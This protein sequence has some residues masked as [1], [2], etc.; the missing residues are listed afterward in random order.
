MGC[1]PDVGVR[2]LD[3]YVV[4]STSLPEMCTLIPMTLLPNSL[5]KAPV[6][7]MF[8]CSTEQC[9]LVPSLV[10]D[11]P[12]TGFLSSRLRCPGAPSSS[13]STCSYSHCRRF[14]IFRTSCEFGCS[15]VNVCFCLL[16]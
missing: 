1:V 9:R 7:N 4:E 5:F 14:R 11:V 8:H 10:S 13:C 2:A 12:N 15:S 3:L 6:L 16:F